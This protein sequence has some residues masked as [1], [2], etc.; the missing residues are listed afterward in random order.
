MIRN[1]IR[2]FGWLTAVI[3]ILCW[4]PAAQSQERPCGLLSEQE[5]GYLNSAVRAWNTMF[6]SKVH[7]D[8]WKYVEDYGTSLQAL[9][10]GTGLWIPTTDKTGV[11][12]GAAP[13]SEENQEIYKEWK[14]GQGTAWPELV[15]RFASQTKDAVSLHWKIGDR[16]FETTALVSDKPPYILD[17]M[18]SSVAILKKGHSCVDDQILWLWGPVRG[19][20]YVDASVIKTSKGFI[21]ARKEDAWMNLGTV[22]I[23]MTDVTYNGNTCMFTY[24]WAFATPF[25][26]LTFKL[27]SFSFEITGLGSG[28]KESGDCVAKFQ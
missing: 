14:T 26:S 12:T 1:N 21:C 13:I 19:E 8:G 4:I 7:L 11:L 22:D 10:S 20:I 9:D 18:L 24:A 25:A 27:D 2:L 6:G 3:S 16:D 15:S 17:S 28:E 23:K 5:C